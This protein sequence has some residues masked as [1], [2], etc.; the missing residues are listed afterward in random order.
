[1]ITK[2][3]LSKLTSEEKDDLIF[4]L[5]EHFQKELQMLRYELQQANARIKELEGQISKNS[6]N[7]SKPPSSDGLKKPNPK[8]QR[9]RGE[10]PTGG[11]QSHPG[12]TLFQVE[13]P[14]VVV[15]HPVEVCEECQQSLRGALLLGHEKRQDI[16]LLSIE[17]VIT[18]HQ[19]EIKICPFYGCKNKGKFPEN[20]TQ[21]IQYGTRVK[22][23]ASYLGAAPQKLDRIS[24]FFIPWVR[25]IT[26]TIQ[27]NINGKDSQATQR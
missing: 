17:P 25:S 19:A 12:T 7:S 16:D 10:K 24:K 13:I 15:T 5:C 2:E 21:P 26:S 3:Q 23:V 27:E 6:R 14:D 18:E 4:E 20:I 22:A 8:S 1:M 11:Q 9:N